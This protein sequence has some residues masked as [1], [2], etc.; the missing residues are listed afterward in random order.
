MYKLMLVSCKSNNRP[1]PPLRVADHLC[2][3][4]CV[5]SCKSSNIP[6]PP[7][8]V[9]DHLCG[10]TCV[11][12]CKSSNIPHPPLRV[13]DHLCGETCVVSC[14]SSNIPHPPLRVA[15]HLCGET[16]VVSFK[17]SNGPDPSVCSGCKSVTWRNSCCFMPVQRWTRPICMFWGQITHMEK[18]MLFHASPTLD[19]THLCVLGGNHSRG[20]TH[21]VSCQ[22]NTGPDPS[23]CSGGKLL[24]WRNTCLFHASP[25]LA[26]TI[27]CV[28]GANKSCGEQ[29]RYLTHD[30][31]LG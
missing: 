11:V 5:V 27:I 2:G 18:L 17:S 1:H 19:Q 4:T 6:H 25:T 15:D 9:A 8:R 30:T 31:G 24:V 20:E 3:E 29:N 28:L 16:C 22:S 23:V 26:H 7:L 10:E 21:V 12:S 14:K 13:A